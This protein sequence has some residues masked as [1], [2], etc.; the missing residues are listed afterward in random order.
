MTD[1]IQLR[2]VRALPFEGNTA[3][4]YRGI[5]DVHHTI[6]YILAGDG[7]IR[8]EKGAL[9]LEPGRVYLIPRGLPHDL[10]C[11]THIR[12]TY[13]DFHVELFPGCD[14]LAE[15]G[16]VRS[17]PAGREVCQ[18]IF[19]A[20]QRK[21]LRD[22]TFLRGQLL[23]AVA[24]F[25]PDNLPGISP[26]MQPFLPIVE[27]MRRNLSASI[28]R[29]EIAARYGWNPSSFSRAFR[30]A[31]GCGFKQY[32]ERLLTE[33]IAEELLVSNKTLQTIA[34]GYGFCD[35]YYLSAFFK[36]TMGTSPAIYRKQH[37]R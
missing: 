13:L 22:R 17:L 37:E 19:D 20:A 31:F 14:A 26:A 2:L 24:A 23:T 30:R 5:C 3:W 15:A 34:E 10:W 28:R 7:H 11:D 27:E 12:K 16:E 18:R 6:Y 21:T 4:N 9:D 8:T 35:A 25:M 1:D 29:E 33:R 32:Q 36:R